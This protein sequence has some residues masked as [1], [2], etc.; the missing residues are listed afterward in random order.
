MNYQPLGTTSYGASVL[1]GRWLRV[2]ILIPK[3]MKTD[4]QR[5]TLMACHNYSYDA[6]I[7]L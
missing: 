7:T 5:S 3:A 2:G 1:P 4:T 6:V